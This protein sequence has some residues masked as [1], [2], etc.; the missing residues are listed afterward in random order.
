MIKLLDLKQA[1]SDMQRSTTLEYQ[2]RSLKEFLTDRYYTARGEI[3][4][5]LGKRDLSISIYEANMLT[6]II[7]CM[8]CTPQSDLDTIEKL[9]RVLPKL[10]EESELWYKTHSI[11]K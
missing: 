1:T 11:N 10:G 5:H 9:K 4:H 3:K 6:N 2:F 7:P 8:R